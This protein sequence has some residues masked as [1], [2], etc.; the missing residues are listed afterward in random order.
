MADAKSFGAYIKKL[1]ESRGYSINQLATYADVSAAHISRIERG[2]R[3]IPT[4]DFIQ[5][6]AKGLRVPYEDLMEQAGYIERQSNH[7]D[8]DAVSPEER[9]FLDW[10]AENLEDTFF[11]DFSRSPEE[12]K[13]EMMETLRFIWE[14]EKRRRPD[15]NQ[16][17]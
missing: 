15:N 17:K 2:L 6:L 3:D 16:E 7:N 11:Y 4:P 8:S 12:S 10:V 9:E 13:R 14:R 1:R 5:K